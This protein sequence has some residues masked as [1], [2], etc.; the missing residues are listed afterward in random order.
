MSHGDTSEPRTEQNPHAEN[1]THVVH[2]V[3]GDEVVDTHA[4]TSESEAQEWAEAIRVVTG[5]P[6]IQ[7]VDS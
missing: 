7:E 3:V 6:V 1:V 5:R 4:A 2:K